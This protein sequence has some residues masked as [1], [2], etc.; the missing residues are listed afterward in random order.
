MDMYLLGWIVDS[1]HFGAEY[2]WKNIC[3]GLGGY[4]VMGSYTVKHVKLGS[5]LL[6]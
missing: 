5:N 2:G 4:P 6:R 3:S 1:F